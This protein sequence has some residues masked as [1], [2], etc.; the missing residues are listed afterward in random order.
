LPTEVAAPLSLPFGPVSTPERVSSIDSLRGFALLWIL[1]SNIDVFSGPETFFEI[2]QGLPDTSFVNAHLHMNLALLFFKWIAEEGK[3]RFL[4]SLLFGVGLCLM[5]ERAERTGRSGVLADIYQRRNLWLCV[6][7]LLHS[8][9][10]WI[11]D[12][13]LTYALAGLLILYPCRKLKA[14]SL[15]IAGCLITCLSSLF[16]PYFLGTAGDIE[17]S[18]QAQSVAA[19]RQAGTTLTADQM[20]IGVQWYA[21][22][23]SH[24]VVRPP[25]DGGP[26]QA[27]SFAELANRESFFTELL[28]SRAFIVMEAVGAMLF[29]MGLYK[30]G[31]LT[32]KLSWKIYI[33][34]ALSG[35]L[36]STPF[37]AIGVEKVYQSQFNFITAEVWLYRPYELLK[38]V[39]GFGM[40]SVLMLVIKSRYLRSPKSALAAVGQMAISNYI[41]TSVICQWI[42]M[43]GPWKLYGKL[44]Y[45]QHHLVMVCIWGLT[46]AF[47]VVWLRR[48]RFG[49]LEWVW[50]SLTYWSLQPMR[51][52]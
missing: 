47:S 15:L 4:F 40:L 48:F 17:L 52:G 16:L 10:I 3:G 19:A 30:T 28:L 36:L 13:L 32:A 41:L 45:L 51:R 42:F 2:P 26:S 6:F 20:I 9:F 29:G 5:T 49:P 44:T 34:C 25:L 39:S 8:V 1:F 38:F 18:R 24:A 22:Q 21:L 14:R 50:R 12:I 46:V 35:I 31:F 7:G 23:A 33:W 27:Q 43:W 11:G 37:L